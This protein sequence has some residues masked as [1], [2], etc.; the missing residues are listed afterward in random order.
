LIVVYHVAHPVPPEAASNHDLLV[1]QSGLEADPFSGGVPEVTLKEA[2]GPRDEAR[3]LVAK[4]IDP[5]V[6]CRYRYISSVVCVCGNRA[7]QPSND[8]LK[9]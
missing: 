7:S 8:L 3:A 5:R 6:H 9:I 2:R 4:G 1:H